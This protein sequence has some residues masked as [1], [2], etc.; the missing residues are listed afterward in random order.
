MTKQRAGFVAIALLALP[1]GSV[2]SEFR[3]LVIR[4]DHTVEEAPVA[5]S[6]YGQSGLVAVGRRD[7]LWHY[8]VIS[9]AQGGV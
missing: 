3:E 9:V 7:E 6:V 8:S 2:A 4:L 1:G 5:I